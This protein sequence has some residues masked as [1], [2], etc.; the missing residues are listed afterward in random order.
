M[1]VWSSDVLLDD[2]AADA[3]F[4]FLGRI[5]LETLPEADG[6]VSTDW[7]DGRAIGTQGEVQDT[8][9]VSWRKRDGGD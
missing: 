2:A 5:F 4:A 1:C 8:T 7:G 6:L 9:L 3:G